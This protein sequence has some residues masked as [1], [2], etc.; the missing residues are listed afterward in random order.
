MRFPNLCK[1]V[2][3]IIY[4][5]MYDCRGD[6]NKCLKIIKRPDFCACDL[7]KNGENVDICHIPTRWENDRNTYFMI[8]NCEELFY[9]ECI[10]CG[11]QI[12]DDCVDGGDCEYYPEC[13]LCYNKIRWY[14]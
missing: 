13:T 9:S 8:T 12:Y 7:H 14:D 1:D 3:N 5:Y 4:D 10:T 2:I 6:F 11:F